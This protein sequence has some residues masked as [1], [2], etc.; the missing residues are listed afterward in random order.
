MNIAKLREDLGVQK[1]QLVI[2]KFLKKSELYRKMKDFSKAQ[3]CTE[4]ALENIKKYKE[5]LVENQFYRYSDISIKKM[6]V[7]AFF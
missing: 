3:R 6:L 7:N 4:I 2:A 1:Q 5:S